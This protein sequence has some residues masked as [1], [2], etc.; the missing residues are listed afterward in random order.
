MQINYPKDLESEQAVLRILMV[1]PEKIVE[2]VDL[3]TASDFY[4]TAN[5]NIWMAIKTVFQEGEHIDVVSVSSQIKKQGIDVPLTIETLRSLYTE[6][7]GINDNNLTHFIEEIKNKSLLRQ[8]LSTTK[9]YSQV[10]QEEGIKA[11]E[12]L[13]TIEKDI[14]QIADRKIDLK[15]HDV[16]GIIDNLNTD[17]IKDKERGWQ[18]FDTGFPMLDKNTGGLLPTMV[19]IVGAYTGFGKTFFMLQILLNILKQG[20]KVILFSTEMD[21]K[22]NMLRLIG[23]LANL[24]TIRIMKDMLSADEKER[25]I[26]AQEEL[27]IYKDNLLIYD[28]VY[29]ASEMRL[30]IKKMKVSGGVNVVIID[31]I[32]NMR[33]EGSGIYEKMS[34]VAIDLYRI[35]QELEVTLII[36]SQVSQAAAGWQSKESIDFKGAGEIA[37]IA[38][39]G[40]WIS[41]TPTDD[42]REIAIRK[43]RHGA[44]GVFKVKFSFPSGRISD[45]NQ[46]K[47]KEERGKFKQF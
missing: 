29:T 14:L 25:V 21:R 36:G 44:P 26:K 42:I 28:N 3:L 1:S 35:A 4:S 15:S 33:G 34:Q 23:N 38:D 37:A 32:Q 8:I 43:I 20:A 10:V 13:E 17:I 2:V 39:V 16:N 6:E 24:G 12:V 11:L 22:V 9:N 5:Q 19:W 47:V 31:Y 41:K 30:K 45:P 18:G 40:I 46:V 27:R 7:L